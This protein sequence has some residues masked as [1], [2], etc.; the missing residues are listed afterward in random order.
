MRGSALL[1]IWETDLETKMLWHWTCEKR[2]MLK[3]WKVHILFLVR[4]KSKPCWRLNSELIVSLTASV[5]SPASCN[6]FYFTIWSSASGWCRL[7]HIYT[8]MSS[9][10]CFNW[11]TFSD[12]KDIHSFL[13]HH[14]IFKSLLAVTE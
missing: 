8:A 4:C 5:T 7:Q 9:L 2:G 11:I 12:L 13:S 10:Q 1:S 6:K 14:F 3:K